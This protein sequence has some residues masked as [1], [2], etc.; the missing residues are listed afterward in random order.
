[1]GVKRNIISLTATLALMGPEL[2]KA[3]ASRQHA[4]IRSINNVN[5]RGQQ[6]HQKAIH[7]SVNQHQH[8]SPQRR[9]ANR[10]R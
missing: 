6:A 2:Q 8:R 10:N 3:T 5:G 1:M 9:F 7:T 4:I